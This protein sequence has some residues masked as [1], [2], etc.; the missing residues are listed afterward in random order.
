MSCQ[1]DASRCTTQAGH[2]DLA[3]AEVCTGQMTPP[4]IVKSTKANREMF[5]CN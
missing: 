1:I 4:Q 2:D 3:D 5:A